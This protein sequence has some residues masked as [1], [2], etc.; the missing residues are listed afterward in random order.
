M[1]LEQEQFI[2]KQEMQPPTSH[3]SINGNQSNG[4]IARLK[5]YSSTGIKIL[6]SRDWKGTLRYPQL[7]FGITS[8]TANDQTS[9]EESGW[10]VPKSSELGARLTKNASFFATN[11]ALFSVLLM[12]YEILSDWTI[13]FW[14]FGVFGI[15]TFVIR[16]AA[17]GK[18]FPIVVS[19]VTIDRNKGYMVM[20]LLTSII[21]IVYVGSTFLFVTGCTLVFSF[22]HS[23]FRNPLSYKTHDSTEGNNLNGIESGGIELGGDSL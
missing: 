22:L 10:N 21:L 17:D 7:F 6:R 9:S 4:N 5:N 13:M 8:T 1:A 16:A 15:W 20:S 18:I 3:V 11:Y 2:D 14:L 12:S 23:T 19:G